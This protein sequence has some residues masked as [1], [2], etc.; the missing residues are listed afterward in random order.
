MSQYRNA[1]PQYFQRT[2]GFELFPLIPARRY[3]VPQ[4]QDEPRSLFFWAAT[5]PE[6]QE[7]MCTSGRSPAQLGW[8]S[9]MAMLAAM[10]G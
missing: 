7:N 8:Y 6:V 9:S 2:V 10:L 5:P 3:P 4:P 1:T